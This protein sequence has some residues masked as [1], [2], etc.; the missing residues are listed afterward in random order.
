MKKRM[1]LIFLYEK[2]NRHSFYVLA[3]ALE[4]DVYHLF[5]KNMT[6]MGRWK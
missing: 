6:S 4:S 5:L 1:A 2:S 3:G